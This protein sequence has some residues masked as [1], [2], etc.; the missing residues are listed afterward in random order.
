MTMDNIE[1]EAIYA[2]VCKGCTR[3]GDEIGSCY[4]PE[5]CEKLIAAMAEYE[6]KQKG[7]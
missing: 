4:L 3:H 5:P 7:E 6:K 1:L 2:A